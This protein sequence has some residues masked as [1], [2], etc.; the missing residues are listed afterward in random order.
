MS[1]FAPKTKNGNK[2][3]KNKNQ[4]SSKKYGQCDSG[5]TGKRLL[6]SLDNQD[7]TR[8]V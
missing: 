6:Y 3:G 4:L 7:F 1:A 2:E 8:H 5:F